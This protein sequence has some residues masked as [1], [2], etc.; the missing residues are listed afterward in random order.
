MGNWLAGMDE[1]SADTVA[2]LIEALQDP[3]PLVRGHAAW[4]LGRTG[5]PVARAALEGRAPIE[6]EPTASREIA[7]A[8]AGR[9]P[10]D[11]A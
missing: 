3:S 1:P 5:S 10:R 2:A 4:A 9:S 8:I 6:E 7:A 11:R